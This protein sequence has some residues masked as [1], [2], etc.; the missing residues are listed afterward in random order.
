[1]PA[2]ASFLVLWMSRTIFLTIRDVRVITQV[3]SKLVM[4]ENIKFQQHFDFVR[5]NRTQRKKI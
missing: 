5:R 3:H 1:M 4:W 2:R